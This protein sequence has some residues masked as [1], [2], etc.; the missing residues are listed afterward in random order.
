MKKYSVEVSLR[1][2]YEYVIEAKNEKQAMMYAEEDA[3]NELTIS[4][5]DVEFSV[6]E[7]KEE[8]QN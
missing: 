3:G 2:R 5:C 8:E 4:D 1:T 7:I 6:T